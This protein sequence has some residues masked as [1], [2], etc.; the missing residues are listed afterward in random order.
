MEILADLIVS[1][2][3]VYSMIIFVYILL[4]WF[5]NAR[6]SSFGQAIGRVVEPYIDMFRQF[7]PNIGM[8]DLSPLV[9]IIVMRVAANGVEHLFYTFLL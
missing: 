6:E 2:M 5:P 9:A 3:R 1:A 8:I 4:S 7:I